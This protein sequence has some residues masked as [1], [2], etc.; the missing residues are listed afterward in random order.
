[1]VLILLFL[2]PEWADSSIAINCIF[3]DSVYN[4]S[5]YHQLKK[6]S[7]FTESSINTFSIDFV[8][9]INNPA[10]DFW[11][12]Y[13]SLDTVSS[14]IYQSSQKLI[15]EINSPDHLI[16]I[17]FFPLELSFSFCTFYQL[18][19]FFYRRFQFILSLS[20]MLF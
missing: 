11:F 8:W 13:I 3:S 9:H 15:F 1:M 5:H 18:C 6:S 2:K 19:R 12:F 17:W 7:K 10:F 16:Q 4:P 20:K 14:I